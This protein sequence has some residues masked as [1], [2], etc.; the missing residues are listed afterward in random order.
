MIKQ[1]ISLVKIAKQ[2]V[3]LQEKSV[4][5]CAS[6]IR[7]KFEYIDSL[8]YELQ[9]AD[10]PKSGSFKDY[11][12]QKVYMQGFLYEIEKTYEEVA[13]LKLKKKELEEVLKAFNIEYEK[14]KYIYDKESLRLKKEKESLEA[15]SLDSISNLLYA[16]KGYNH[17]KNSTNSSM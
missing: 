13:L 8:N 1:L 2:N 11:Q 6:E 9:N 10:V 14:L 15:K 17:E 5:A 4:Q 12:S 3:D 7:L 16:N